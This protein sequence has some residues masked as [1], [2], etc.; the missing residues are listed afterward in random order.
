ID[1]IQNEIDLFKVSEC[2]ICI[3]E[4]C[5]TFLPKTKSLK[6]FQQNVRSIKRNIDGLLPILIKSNLGWDYIVLT[7]CWLPST[8]YI[9]IGYNFSATTKN[10]TQNEGV[11][12][13]YRQDLVATIEEPEILDANCLL[14]KPSN[15][16][17]ILTIY[18]PPGYKNIDNF[19][20]SLHNALL[21][22]SSIQNIVVL[23]D[24][25]ID[26]G[27]NCKDVSSFTFLEMLALHGILPAHTFPTHS[28]TCLDHVLLK[29]KKTAHC[30]VLQTSLTDHDSV[31]LYLASWQQTSTPRTKKCIDHVS[32]SCNLKNSYFNPLYLFQNFHPHSFVL[33][34]TNV[35]EVSTIVNNLK[36]NTAAGL[37]GIPPE[38]LKTNVDTL[39]DPIAFICNLT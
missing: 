3:L 4:E 31:V 29:T 22:Y 12:V 26:I 28:K 6:I 8:P 38:I 27:E 7:D 39:S 34:P 30:L 10:L 19:I 24:M 25:D 9:P 11:V 21:K 17:I 33:F 13:Y 2:S 15:N 5:Q 14:V 16:T 18:R 1:K 20:Q 23:G 36:L 35:H 32:L 37:D